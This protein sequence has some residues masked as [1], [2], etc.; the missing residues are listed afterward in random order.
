MVESISTPGVPEGRVGGQGLEQ[1]AQR[2][3][4]DPAAEP[5]VHRV[6][7]AELA[8]QVAPRGAGAGQ[9]QQGLEEVALGEEGGWPPLCRLACWTSGRIAARRSSV[10]MYRMT[11]P[12]L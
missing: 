7:G 9:V 2:A 5:V 8:G 11:A 3:G 4:G 6:P 12:P 10:S 1:P